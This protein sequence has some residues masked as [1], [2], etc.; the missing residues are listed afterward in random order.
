MGIIS[1]QEKTKLGELLSFNNIDLG[2]MIPLM[3]TTVSATSV[4]SVT[5]SSIPQGYEHLQIRTMVKTNEGTTGA[6]NIEMRF[7][8]DTAANYTRHYL[9][10]NGSTV[11][12]GGGGGTS[13]LT[14]GS[15]A[16]GGVAN[17]FGISV[18][19]IL[20]YAN[21]N[22]NKTMRAL[23]GVDQNT[24]GSRFIW[25]GQ[26]GVWINTSAIT[27]ISLFS[28]SS[29]ISQYSSFALYGIKRAGA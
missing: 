3:T 23:S 27:S 29:N 4:A 16:Q 7:N 14:T 22:K 8:S 1:L 17:T 25:G 6:T 28:A 13:Y 26:S 10:G 11:S 24:S 18:I 21:T 2:G 5:F 20:D 9:F 19:D 12:A 15:A